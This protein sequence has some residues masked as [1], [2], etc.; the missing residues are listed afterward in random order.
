MFEPSSHPRLFALPPGVD[1]PKALVEGII[2]R[3][4]GR[5]PEAM[6]R[7]TVYLNTAR[8]LR[9]VRTLFDDYGSRFLPRLRLVTDIGRDPLA[10]LPPAVPPLR[11]RLELA[12]LVE[13]RFRL[14]LVEIVELT[15]FPHLQVTRGRY[16]IFHSR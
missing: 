8:M 12:E 9:R 3:M 4:E 14:A 15:L 5:P 6:A 7:V 16:G 13:H 10:G 2:A 1:F 11:R